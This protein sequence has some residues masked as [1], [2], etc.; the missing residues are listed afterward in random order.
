MRWCWNEDVGTQG[1]S[2][3][4]IWLLRLFK[5][6]LIQNKVQWICSIKIPSL[7]V[8]ATKASDGTTSDTLSKPHFNKTWVCIYA[9]L[10]SHVWLFVTPWTVAHQAPL[11]MGLSGQE[12]WNGLPFR[13]PGYLP[14]PGIKLMSPESPALGGGFFTT[15]PPGKPSIKLRNR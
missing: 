1:L 6:P 2:H 14:N 5:L 7:Q 4:V 13:P 3:S 9:Q 15:V 11:S 8:T 10:L 12:C